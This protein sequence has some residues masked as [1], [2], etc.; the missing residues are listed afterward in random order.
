MSRNGSVELHWAGDLR[1]FKLGIDELLVLQ[2]KLDS[3]PQEIANRLR[4]HGWRVD[5]IREV[6][7]LGL[8]G[9]GTEPVIA[10]R[11]IEEHVVPGRL[12]SNAMVAFVVMT[13]AILGDEND[14][15]GKEAAAPEAPGA[16]DSPAPPSTGRV[17]SSATRRKRSAK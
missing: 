16:T 17:R 10:R 3:G 4:L 1:S 7:R 14:P 13:A 8:S 6:L 12:Q 2:D 11:L 15:V 9:G 5:D